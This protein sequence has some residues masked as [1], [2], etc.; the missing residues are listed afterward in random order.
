MNDF[1][2]KLEFYLKS[3]YK[4]SEDI[5]EISR[6]IKSILNTSDKSSIEKP[7]WSQE[8][9]FLISYADTITNNSEPPLK[10]L[11]NFL[12][13]HIEGINS[14]HILPFMPS[15]SDYGFSVIDY[16]SIN[17][18]NGSWKEL[19]DISDSYNLMMD[20]VLNHSST[21]SVWF[22][23]YIKGS[24]KGSDYFIEVGDWSGIPQVARPRTSELFQK[25]ETKNGDKLVWCT[26]SRDQVDLN[27]KNPKVLIE[28]IKIFSFY[29]KKGIRTF[30]L[31][32]VAYIWKEE[33]TN[34]INRPETHSIVKTLRLIIE[35]MDNRA[36][37]ITETNI[38][39]TENLVYFGKS[40][41][42]HWI[43]NFTLSPLILY[44]LLRGDCSI[45]RKWAMTMPP[46]KNGNAYFNFLAS[47]DGIGL[48]PMEGYIDKTEL[49][50]F[51]NLMKSFGGEISYRTSQWGDKNPYEI[52]IS[53]LDS[54]RGTFE[55]VDN[56]MFN[57]FICAH[58]IMFS[59]EG[60]PAIYIHSLLGTRNDY[61]SIKKG[62]E[63]RSINRFKWEKN[64][65]YKLL[66]NSKSLN[67]KILSR[68]KQIL[69]I[70]IKQPAF[71][72][73][74][75]QF[76]LNLGNKTFGLWRQDAD[77]TQ[78]IF[79]ITNIT[80][81]SESIS[82]SEINLIETEDWFDLLTS[83][84][85]KGIN[86]RITMKPYQTLWITNKLTN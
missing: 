23:N 37:L 72:P 29:I 48:R 19:R 17:P 82:L 22:N 8:D 26:F 33:N 47:H 12:D 31:D 3:I 64:K 61:E 21:Q 49:T 39:N 73:N 11:K 2:N 75:T 7:V 40:N 70:R 78:S 42:A 24:G 36:I 52:N 13:D 83:K 53:F 44:T 86:D 56:F 38:P 50:R 46:A 14:I 69:K 45:L 76:T 63:N 85:L 10:T 74:S 77:R 71:H 59:F 43:Y 81:S 80:K 27:F 6:E 51:L 28:F 84:K 35:H 67:A 30:R 41:E 54:L 16:Y 25:F 79:C 57:R 4:D 68:I 62:K 9:I 58:T 32:A 34:C 1:D 60:V 15:S 65:I 66:S 55:G 18:K 20:I 5:N